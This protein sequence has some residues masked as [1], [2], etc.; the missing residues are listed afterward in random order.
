MIGKITPSGIISQF[1]T[2]TPD[3]RPQ[4][5]TS[6]SDGTLW[7]TEAI[8]NVGKVT[9]SGASVRMNEYSLG[10]ARLRGIT[11]GPDQNVWVTDQTNDAV[12]RVS[13]SSP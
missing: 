4:R 9:L 11:I 7:F 5:I 2:Q 6:A 8:G 1:P 3:A 12:D 13:A 10:G